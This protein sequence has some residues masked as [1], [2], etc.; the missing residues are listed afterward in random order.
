M[1]HPLV[2]TL[3]LFLAPQLGAQSIA[4]RLQP[5]VQPGGSL[6]SLV[7]GG[8][9]Q[10][11]L[12][13]FDVQGGPRQLLGETFFLGFTPALTLIDAGVLNGVGSRSL[14]LVMPLAQ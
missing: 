3:A 9:G 2:L 7:L 8:P 14:R 1:K 5:A 12:T 10:A 13:F 4:Y 11:F 6:D